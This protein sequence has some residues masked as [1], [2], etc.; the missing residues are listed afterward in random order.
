MDTVQLQY[1][2]FPSLIFKRRL[3][4]LALLQQVVYVT[5]GLNQGFDF[6][7]CGSSL[8]LAHVQSGARLHSHEVK[9]TNNGGSSGQNSVTGMMS[10]TDANSMWTIKPPAGGM[11]ESGLP[12]KC[13]G[14]IRLQHVKTGYN[15]S[16]FFFFCEYLV[17]S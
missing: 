1:G 5:N 10:Q 9:Y 6:V 7:T 3:L 12:V 2:I 14:A 11:C 17:T 4:L 8:K 15:T 13:G 16:K